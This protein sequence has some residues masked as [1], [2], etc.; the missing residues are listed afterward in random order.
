MIQRIFLILLAAII[1]LTATTAISQACV[2]RI[3]YVGAMETIESRTMA[4]L[5][6]LLINERTGTNV[7]IRYYDDN[8]KLY[9]AFQ[10]HDEEARIDII[11]ENSA[12]A[13]AYLKKKR[14]AD[15]DQEYLEVKKIYEKDLNVIWLKPFGFRNYKGPDNQSISAPLIRNDV[16]TNYPL[17]PR[18][19]TKLSG[20]IDEQT[21]TEIIGKVKSGDKAKNV[22]KNFLRTKKFI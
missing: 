11:I 19:L 17:L 5:L 7:K 9:Q 21:F 4:E 8:N 6:V 14:L 10:S 13:M 20:A 2:G 16:L 3:L 1:M 15:L 18:I 12:D 22:V